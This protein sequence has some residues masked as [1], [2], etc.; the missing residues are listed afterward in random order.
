MPEGSPHEI[1]IGA[2]IPQAPLELFKLP[3]LFSIESIEQHLA[4]YDVSTGETSLSA[5]REAR[6]EIK[7]APLVR[8]GE[9]LA[10]NKSVSYIKISKHNLHLPEHHFDFTVY[11]NEIERKYSMP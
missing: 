6:E 1:A 7:E 10:P 3:S 4:M 9:H 8:G 5:L 11:H 2:I